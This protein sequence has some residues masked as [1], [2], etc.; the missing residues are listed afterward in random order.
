MSAWPAG[1]G[2]GTRRAAFRPSAI[3]L[4][5]VALFVTSGWM[6]WAGFGAPAVNVILF[7]VS[8]WLVS[9]CLHEYA[10]ALTAYRSGDLAVAERGYL[11]LNPLRYT[12]PVLSIALPL[13]YLFLGGIGLPGGAVWI[14]HSH[15]RGRWRDSLI[16]LAG[17]LLNVVFTVLAVLPFAVV[18]TPVG[19]H[20]FW[21]A[22]AFLGFLQLT[23]S[24]LNLAPV[25]GVDGGNALRPWLPYSWRRGF[26]L[27]APYGLLIFLVLLFNPR[28]G[29]AFFS[30]VFGLG[31]LLGLPQNLVRDGHDQFMFWR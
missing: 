11:T 12:S 15:I 27:I 3:F 8:G 30:A 1:R 25:P 9:L 5:L 13:F 7:V 18:G 31:D 6:A 28:V 4:G 16:S 24:L 10:H 21:A 19:H 14:D 23:A 2:V 17:P 20:M 22:L 26:D 29:G